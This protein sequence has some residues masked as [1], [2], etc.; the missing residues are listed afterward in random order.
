MNADGRNMFDQ[1]L[2]VMLFRKTVARGMLLS[3]TWPY[4]SKS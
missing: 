3:S 4:L 2:I 1:G